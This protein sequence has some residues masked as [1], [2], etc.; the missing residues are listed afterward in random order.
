VCNG[1]RGFHKFIKY[2]SQQSEFLPGFIGKEKLMTA[3]LVKFFAF[4]SAISIIIF[5]E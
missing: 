1:R 4:L 3:V 2:T 5:F